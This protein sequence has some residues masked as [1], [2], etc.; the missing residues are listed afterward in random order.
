M[1][2]PVRTIPPILLRKMAKV[3]PKGPNGWLPCLHSF[4]TFWPIKPSYTSNQIWSF[5]A[6]YNV[7]KLYMYRKVMS[8]RLSRL[9]AHSRIF[10]LFMTE[11]FDAYVLWPLSERVQNWIVDQSTAAR[12]FTVYFEK[13]FLGKPDWSFTKK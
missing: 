3:I 1:L 6:H 4:K 7:L 13:E 9:V 10:R 5:A 2:F 11:K 8:S 12:N